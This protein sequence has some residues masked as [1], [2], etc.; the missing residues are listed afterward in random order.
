MNRLR[1][2]RKGK[3]LTLRELEIETGIRDVNLS[4]YER[5][6]VQPRSGVWKI[7]ANYYDVPI[8]YLKGTDK[9]IDDYLENMVDKNFR[10]KELRKSK[11][12]ILKN[13]QEQT[14]IKRSTFSDYENSN[15]EPNI[16]T[17]IALADYFNVSIDYLVGRS[18][19]R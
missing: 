16:K 12:L 8:I 4:R 13:I 5:G 7:L 3:K 9:E 17:L 6:A 1:E 14:G 11:K 18:D 2:L 10:L 19:V 15:T